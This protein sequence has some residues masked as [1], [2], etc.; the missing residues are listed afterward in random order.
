MMKA[1]KELAGSWRPLFSLHAGTAEPLRVSPPEA[2]VYQD[3]IDVIENE[4]GNSSSSN[5]RKNMTFTR[6]VIP[7][8]IAGIFSI[9]AYS[10]Q[11][12]QAAVSAASSAAQ[13]GITSEP[14]EASGEID[15]EAL[16]VG[17]AKKLAGAK[18][19]SVSMHMNYDVVQ[20]SGQKIQ[21]GEVREVQISRPNYLRVGS[22]QSD[23]DAGGL[24]FDGKTLTLFSETENVYSQTT[25]PGDVDAAVRYAVA[26]L[27]I[28][29]PLARMLTSTLPQELQRLNTDVVYVEH[30]ILGSMPTDHI[31]VQTR[32]VDYQVWI[33]R[34]MLPTRMILTY[35]N[36]PG[37]PQF[38]AVFSSWNLTPIIDE[39]TF[40]FTP[41]QGAERIP[42]LLPASRQ[43]GMNK[44]QGGAS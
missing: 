19:F 12:E 5:R 42:T 16:L 28:R 9:P 30:N 18:Q 26:K 6:K 25:H 29:V 38:E 34:D 23:G 3:L 13:S 37:Q 32:D 24:I 7:L 4:S 43:D 40:T 15:A 31:A 39:S 36:A 44:T 2:V 35:K 41:A 21:F 27:G 8:I 11:G 33:G 1:P 14:K 22:Q 17:M 10:Q 20:E